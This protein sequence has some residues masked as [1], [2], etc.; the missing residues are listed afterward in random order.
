MTLVKES[1]I[2]KYLL[3]TMEP[4]KFKEV[5]KTYAENQPEYQP[6]PGCFVPGDKGEFI[7]C[8]KGTLKER[9]KFLL[10][11]KMWVSMFTFNDPLTPSFHTVFK[12]DIFLQVRPF[13]IVRRPGFLVFR[14]FGYGLSISKTSVKGMKSKL[15]LGYSVTVLTPKHFVP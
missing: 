3:H 10:T 4:I 7:F 5:N 15:I 6:I 12:S 13:F 9:L 8:L 1:T 11:G 2:K 14:V